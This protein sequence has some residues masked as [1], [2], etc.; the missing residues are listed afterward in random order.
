MMIVSI[1]TN[2]LKQQHVSVFKKIM[3][4]TCSS[5]MLVSMYQNIY[6]TVPAHHTPRLTETSGAI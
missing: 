3:V 1:G 6:D 2:L 4:A 5:E